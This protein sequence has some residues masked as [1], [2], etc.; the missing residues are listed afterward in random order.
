MTPAEQQ[1]LTPGDWGRYAGLLALG[2]LLFLVVTGN[3]SG[4]FVS[5]LA[6]YLVLGCLVLLVVNYRRDRS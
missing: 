4:S 2:S 5:L 3:R 1:R 6:I